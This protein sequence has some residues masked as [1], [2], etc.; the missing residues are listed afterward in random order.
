VIAELNLAAMAQARLEGPRIYLRRLTPADVSPEYLGWMNDPDTGRYLESRFSRH[1]LRSLTNFVAGMAAD[2]L[3]FLAG[4]FLKDSGR[5]IGNIKL[6]PVDPLHRRA[7]IGLLI[8]EQACWGK[9]FATE[10]ISLITQFAF[11]E[12]GLHRVT[13]GAY[14]GNVG[15]VRAFEKAGWQQ[16]ARLPS[17]WRCDE[18]YQDGILLGCINPRE[19]DG[20]RGPAVS[21]P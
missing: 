1:D 10:A 20:D 16:E 8:G 7:V 15:S 13:A 6:G 14:A 17:H 9:G 3:N 19:T 12:V 21:A 2:P 11:E 18:G 5:H 4:I